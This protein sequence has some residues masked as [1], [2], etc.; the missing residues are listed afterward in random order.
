MSLTIISSSYTSP[1]DYPRFSSSSLYSSPHCYSR[2]FVIITLITYYLSSLFVIIILHQLT[3]LPTFLSIFILIIPPRCPSPR[4][5]FLST[6]ILMIPPHLP[7]VFPAAST[8]MTP[9]PLLLVLI[10]QKIYSCTA[11]SKSADIAPLEGKV[12]RKIRKVSRGKIR[13]VK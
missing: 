11:K 3:T 1:L 7:S 2:F 5:P 9:L 10:A 12:R 8:V 4:Y 6:F 13:R